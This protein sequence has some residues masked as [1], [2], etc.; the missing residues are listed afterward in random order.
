MKLQYLFTFDRYCES[1]HNNSWY[2]A[3]LAAITETNTLIHH[4]AVQIHSSDVIIGAMASQITGV[5]IVYL[6]VY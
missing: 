6:T 3:P 4:D 2:M 1:S 5:P